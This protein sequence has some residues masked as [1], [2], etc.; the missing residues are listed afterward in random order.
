ML[1]QFCEWLQETGLG[2][3]VRESEFLFPWFESLHV[4][5][6][7]LVVGSIAVVD[8]RLLN[9]GLRDRPISRLMAEVLPLTRLAFLGALIT[10]FVLFVSQATSYLHNTP[11][12]VKMLLL[13]VA[14]INIGF[15]HL[16]TARSIA[17]WDTDG[18][19][20]TRVQL[21]GGTS[22]VLWIGIVGFGRWIGFV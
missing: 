10:G 21:A 8:V 22:L 18:V 13:L 15:F 7:A 14:L 17:R 12:Q 16:V 20:P 11:F 2:I 4:L 19:P 9:W 3:A 1:E 5:M 6:I